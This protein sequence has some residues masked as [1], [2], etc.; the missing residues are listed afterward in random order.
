M[1]P[2]EKLM[3]EAATTIV[4]LKARVD[5]LEARLGISK[6]RGSGSTPADALHALIAKSQRPNLLAGAGIE[7]NLTAVQKRAS[8]RSAQ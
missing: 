5:E 8:R 3:Q 7:K 2:N 4:A 1:N 6:S